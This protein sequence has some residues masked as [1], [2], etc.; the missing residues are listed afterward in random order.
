[1]S[2]SITAQ[3]SQVRETTAKLDA[4]AD[5]DTRLLFEVTTVFPFRLFPARIM[6]TRSKV[7]IHDSYFF[8]SK[9]VHTI[10][11]TD[12]VRVDVEESVLFATI[13]ILDKTLNTQELRV[14]YL[15][16]DDARRVRRIIDGLTLAAREGI[17]LTQVPDGD[18]L[19]KV[20]TLGT[21]QK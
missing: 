20:E 17:D 10:L 4:H 2:D 6:I 18:L 1:M 5:I 11:V 3:Q 16:K 9:L 21:T 15:W 12:I 13:S 8:M 19:D 7:T 14:D